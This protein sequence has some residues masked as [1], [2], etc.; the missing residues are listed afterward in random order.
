MIQCVREFE[1]KVTSERTDLVVVGGG[2]AGICAAITASREGARVCLIEKESFLGGKIGHLTRFPLDQIHSTPQVYKRESGLLDEFWNRQIHDNQEGSYV[3]QAT[4]FKEWV[5]NEK[6]IR[7]FLSCELLSVEK[8]GKKIESVLAINRKS[9][10]RIAF[11]GKYFLDCTGVGKL[12][13]MSKVSGEKGLDLNEL[14]ARRD[15]SIPIIKRH[16]SCVIQIGKGNQNYSFGKPQWITD[17][18]EENSLSAQVALLESL[19]REFTGYH[20]VEWHGESNS[21]PT[22]SYE[23][24][25]IAWDFLKNRSFVKEI[26]SNYQLIDVSPSLFSPSHFRGLGDKILK[27]DDIS[28]GSRFEDAVAL[29]RSFASQEFGSLP[30]N[31]SG[32]SIPQPFEIPFGSLYSKDCGNLLWA[33]GGASSSGLASFCLSTPSVGA[34]MGVAIG[35]IASKCISKNRL[36]RTLAKKGYIDEI[37]KGLQRQNHQCSILPVSENDNLASSASCNASSSLTEWI[38]CKEDRAQLIR[39]KNCQIQFPISEDSIDRIELCLEAEEDLEIELKMYEGTGHDCALPGRCL[40]TERVCFNSDQTYLSIDLGLKPE[41]SGWHFLEL[42]SE[43]YFSVPLFENG[44]VGYVFH[45]SNAG[46]KFAGKNSLTNFIPEIT[47]SPKPSLSPKVKISPPALTYGPENILN[48]YWRP[49]HLPQLWISQPTNFNFPEFLEIEWANSQSISSLE[50]SFDPSYE[51]IYPESPC[52]MPYQNMFSLVKDYKVYFSDSTGKSSL[53]FE[54][55]GNQ[56][57]MRKH[58]FDTIEAKGIE[59]EIIST[60]GINRAQ[61]YQV[62]VF[63]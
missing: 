24:A 8:T 15:E 63:P 21:G 1:M 6:G 19:E 22:D 34:Q 49:N 51:F 42:N 4:I 40:F 54:V 7:L 45:H 37:I 55:E 57:P 50:I 32:S 17:T 12:A 11:V 38:D 29:G 39:T 60:H 2:I 26:L 3:G 62:R 18:W 36:P 30:W 56:M 5:N 10:E 53:L 46:S 61:V 44:V 25:L 28:N 31:Q 9:D 20:I 58:L 23:L 47:R 35:Y 41:N 59:L 48:D 13:E 14:P 52:A 33:G 43:L 16:S 27:L